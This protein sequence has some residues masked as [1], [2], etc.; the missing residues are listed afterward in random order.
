MTR[1][2]T[3]I[4]EADI[5]ARFLSASATDSYPQDLS[6]FSVV[7]VDNPRFQASDVVLFVAT[8]EPGNFALMNTTADTIV[9][10]DQGEATVDIIESLSV[11]GTTY[12]VYRVTSI[13][14][15]NRYEV[16]RVTTEDIIVERNNI[17]NLQSDVARINAELSHAALN[18]PDAVI[19][20]LDNDVSVTEESTPTVMATDYNNQ[21]AGASNAT[22]T[23]FYE[24]SPN[25]PSGGT[26][27][28][29]QIKDTTGARA[30]RKLIYLDP[31][32]FTNQAYLVAF[33]G[34]SGSE[35]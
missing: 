20:V 5:H 33:D 9:A 19:D 30:R 18:L 14:S 6:Q 31:Q 24:G 27:D 25:T 26:L 4:N 2:T 7:S 10:L 1:G 32:T 13:V 35:T 29:N 34:A 12:F 21:L 16:Q 8:P 17:A 15:G 11:S 23:V 28:S 3:T 22:Q